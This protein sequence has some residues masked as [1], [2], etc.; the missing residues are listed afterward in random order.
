MTTIGSKYTLMPSVESVGL[1]GEVRRASHIDTNIDTQYII[2]MYD[3]Q[4]LAKHPELHERVLR[5]ISCGSCDHPNIAGICDVLDSNGTTCIVMPYEEQCDILSY[6][7]RFGYFSENDARVLFQQLVSVATFCGE[8]NLA[9][10]FTTDNISISG[11]RDGTPRIRLYN[12]AMCD[13]QDVSTQG[14]Q[15]RAPED[16]DA[17]IHVCDVNTMSW[18]CGV[19]LYVLVT[20]RVPFHSQSRRVL[21]QKI[22]TEPLEIPNQ[23]SVLLTDLL[24]E[25]LEKNPRYRCCLDSIAKHGWF[26]QGV[27]CASGDDSCFFGEPSI[28]ES[29]TMTMLE[30]DW[31]MAL[32]KREGIH[33]PLRGS[34]TFVDRND[35]TSSIPAMRRSKFALAQVPTHI[36]GALVGIGLETQRIERTE[37]FAEEKALQRLT[38]KK[39][40][41]FA[42]SDD[43]SL[44]RRHEKAYA[45]SVELGHT[46]LSQLN[47]VNREEIV[48]DNRGVKAE[49]DLSKWRNSRPT[50]SRDSPYRGSAASRCQTLGANSSRCDSLE[51]AKVSFSQQSCSSSRD[52]KEFHVNL[53]PQAQRRDAHADESQNR[54]LS[55]RIGARVGLSAR[56]EARPDAGAG[57]RPEFEA[58]TG[59][60]AG[61]GLEAGGI[62]LQTWLSGQLVPNSKSTTWALENERA[63][64]RL[65]GSAGIEHDR[66]AGIEEDPGSY[67][68]GFSRA[69]KE[70]ESD[71]FRRL[72]K[73]AMS[74]AG[75]LCRRRTRR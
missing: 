47:G 53:K 23:T 45:R 65:L 39:L 60:S 24:A 1:H 4:K 57:A 10:C 17:Q 6:V 54:R 38:E 25:L 70:S 50:Q 62:H 44:G 19:L 51:N 74:A 68:C 56:A 41:T 69:G 2:K 18:L 28:A 66:A 58:K 5:E 32:E 52:R 73:N 72:C 9:H 31:K 67:R 46:A 20:G 37:A 63:P 12:N 61:A 15:F 13:S 27:F 75:R 48:W 14:L 30:D 26:T 42:D 64:G 16:M 3:G 43:K 59:A 29:T 11:A 35:N 8:H 22:L 40:W 7:S 34:C 71:G 33:D 55:R 36:S 21:R 49:I